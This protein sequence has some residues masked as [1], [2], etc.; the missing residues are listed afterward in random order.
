MSTPALRQLAQEYAA[1]RAKRLFELDRA[2]PDYRL[3][4]CHEPEKH[5]IP[6]RDLWETTPPKPQPLPRQG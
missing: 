2:V 4:H 3:D 1:L 6:N 5:H